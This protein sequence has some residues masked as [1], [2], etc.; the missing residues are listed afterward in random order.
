MS[1]TYTLV[2]EKTVIKNTRGVI[3]FFSLIQNNV[4]LTRFIPH[5]SKGNKFKVDRFLQMGQFGKI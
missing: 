3:A 4:C 2:A 1:S 5:N